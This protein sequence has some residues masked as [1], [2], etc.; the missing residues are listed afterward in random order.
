MMIN[1]HYL[2]LFWARSDQINSVGTFA[3]RVVVDND[4][5]GRIT[6]DGRMIGGRVHGDTLFVAALHGVVYYLTSAVPEVH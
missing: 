4:H 6:R 5:V 1:F 2:D 3:E